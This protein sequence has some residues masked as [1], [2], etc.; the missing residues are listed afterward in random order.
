[1]THNDLIKLSKQLDREGKELIAITDTYI[2]VYWWKD[3][4]YV[5]WQYTWSNALGC[6]TFLYGD[7]LSVK[8]ASKNEAIK[9]FSERVNK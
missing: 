2:L 9:Q 3:K 5:S 8:G 4:S 1:M 6:Y 7:Y